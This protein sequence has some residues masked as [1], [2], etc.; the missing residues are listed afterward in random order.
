MD[1]TSANKLKTN[2]L[3]SS[4]M[5]HKTIWIVVFAIVVLAGVAYGAYQYGRSSGYKQGYDFGIKNG[6][7][8]ISTPRSLFSDNLPTPQI[9][10]GTIKSITADAMVINTSKGE[11]KEI[12]LNDQTKVTQKTTTLKL[13]DLK[14][15]QK[16]TIFTSG[17]QNALTA[18]R[19]VIQIVK[20]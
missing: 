16:I 1:N 20:S 8:T 15:G 7:T 9:T 4:V 14:V 19:I 17:E 5:K 3:T 10:V 18:T 2:K 11:V 6:R 12:K 13:S